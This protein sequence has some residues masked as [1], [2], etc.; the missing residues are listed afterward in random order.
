MKTDI[1]LNLP[2]KECKLDFLMKISSLLGI[3]FYSQN[4]NWEKFVGKK[5][6]EEEFI[7][8]VIHIC[9]QEFNFWQEDKKIRSIHPFEWGRKEKSWEE[10]DWNLIDK[11]LLIKDQTE[12][13]I[14]LWENNLLD[15]LK[16]PLFWKQ[17]NSA[18]N[19][20]EDPVYKKVILVKYILEESGFNNLIYDVDN[21][22]FGCIDYNIPLV[23]NFFGIIDLSKIDKGNFYFNKENFDQIRIELYQYCIYITET[24]NIKSSHLDEFLFIAGRKLRKQFNQQIPKVLDETNY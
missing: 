19:L 21:W 6:I 9:A 23:F 17:M 7:K 8:R 16:N 22:G 5:E 12:K 10:L 15:A 4:R 18:F 20:I 13:F 24:L 1:F 11:R 14:Q 2:A 3:P